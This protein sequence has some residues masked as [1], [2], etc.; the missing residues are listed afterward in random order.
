MRLIDVGFQAT[1]RRM[2]VYNILFEDAEVDE[3]VLALDESSRVL[4]ITGAGCSVAGHVSGR[5]QRVDAV[6]I[7]KHHLA[8]TAL[9]ATAAQHLDSYASF[10]DLCGRGWHSDPK[11]TIGLFG[12][13]MPDWIR[14][15]WK[16]H[17]DRFEKS[18]YHEGLTAQMVKGVRMMSG[19][20]A[21]WLRTYMHEPV[22]KRIA[23]VDE[24]IAP[25]LRSPAVQMIMRSPLQLLSLGINFSQRDRLL[26]TEQ[27]D[28]ISYF[29]RHLYRVAETELETNWI[30]WWVLAGHFN[31]D[32]EDAVPPYLRRDRWE[33]SLG[34]P[35]RMRYH[36]RNIFDLLGEGGRDE[37]S[38]Y[39]LCDAP[40]WMPEPVQRNL[41]SEIRRTSEDGAIVLY[42]TVEDDCMVSNLGLD[43][44][45]VRQ[46]DLSAEATLA[47]RS[48]QYKHVHV[49]RVAH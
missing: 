23:A 27:T 34:S 42:R 36:N 25:V 17:H 43:R 49:Y 33:R 29:L 41:L 20:D 10:Y 22:E 48:R 1:F 45:F 19:I 46:D 26:E 28:L 38:H 30:A 18:M 15:Y 11:G 24:W 37:W 14:R 44:W 13:E 40:D 5:P 8:L 35:T 31:H 21:S 9:K 16:R 39:T 7:N 47:D 32:R 6:D 12:N 4:S 2:F 3:K